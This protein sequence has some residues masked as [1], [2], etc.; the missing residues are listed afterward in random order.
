MPV[1]I[2]LTPTTLVAADYP[3]AQ[4]PVLGGEVLVYLS[5]APSRLLGTALATSDGVLSYK[6]VGLPSASPGPIAA[7]AIGGGVFQS[8]ADTVSFAN[9]HGQFT[10]AGWSSI[11]NFNFPVGRAVE[12]IGTYNVPVSSSVPVL[13]AVAGAGIL[14]GSQFAIMELPL[15]S[16][17]TLAGC[18]TERQ[19]TVPSRGTKN[20]ACGMNEAEWTTPGVV[21]TG[22]LEI[23]GLNQGVDDGLL[24]FAGVKCQAMLVTLREG[25]LITSR[26]VCLDWTGECKTP[27]PTG[28]SEATVSLSGSF[29]KL[30]MFP[31]P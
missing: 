6:Y 9:L 15:L 28:E 20:I 12:L 25:R 11:T 18:T 22:M 17:F 19:V 2:N 26:S 24:R 31:A 10:P 3:T 8:A 27:Y 23:T 29:S 14:A 16:Q 5:T 4:T 1:T 21:K 7:I 30:C 13:Q